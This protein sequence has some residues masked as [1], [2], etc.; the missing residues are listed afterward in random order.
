[1]SRYISTAF[2]AMTL[3]LAVACG[4]GGSSGSSTTSMSTSVMATGAIT[5]FGSIYVDGVHFQTAHATIHK[6]GVLV[7]QS[8]LA[9]GEIARVKGVK[10]ADGTGDADSV[11]VD[12]NVVGPIATLD[13]V[14]NVLTVLGQTVKI[15]TG[16]SFSNDIQPESI[17]GLKVGDMIRVSGT[18][19]AQGDVVA[20]RIELSA[21]GTPLQVLGT[22]SHLDTTAHKFMINALN[23][24]YSSANLSGFS[25]GQ[26]SE[27]DL[28]DARG[29]I[30][31]ETST[32]L[33]AT[34]V[35]HAENEQEQASGE[36][37]IEREGLITRFVSATDFDVN[38]QPVTT[39]SATMYKNGM[40]SD[41]ALNVKVEVEG[42]Y[43]STNVLV[44]SVVAFH[45]NGS[46]QLQSQVT[47]VDATA[48]TLTVLG[49]HVTVTTSTRLED[50]SS[51]DKQM[52]SLSD[53]SV[54]DV[55]DVTGY[56]SPAG[57]GMV[58]ATRLE[59]E[60]PTNTV[61]VEG[62]YAAGMSPLF[63][64]FGIT[65]D[66]S[67]ATLKGADRKTVTLAEFNTQA[68]GQNVEATGTLSGT[69]VQ[70]SEARIAHQHD[71]GGDD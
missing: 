49:I 60:S 44:A 30:F 8:Q 13:N 58:I 65:V 15:N 2:V 71:H 6:N 46:I 27:G 47:A 10:H 18:V 38:N 56:E 20:T 45:H 3:A 39:T 68:V 33:M 11:E 42:S 35:E 54:G 70:A 66:A 52:F 41:L 34:E 43:N 16:T 51:A 28:V 24:D 14:N 62:P 64:A 23:V 67:T 21:A 53:V 4:G 63:T 26:P 32:T 29:S 50:K 17:D 5:G 57:S 36:N 48:G 31:T 19:D 7:D 22:V 69:T 40:E 9:V 37:D 61:I 1:M 55:V 59:R 25:S 12:E